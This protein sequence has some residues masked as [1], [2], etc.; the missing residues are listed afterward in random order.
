MPRLSRQF[1]P[2]AAQRFAWRRWLL[3][4]SLL[5]ALASAPANAEPLPKPI[6][7]EVK[8]TRLNVRARPGLQYEA[9]GQ[10][11]QGD[12][13][14]VLAVEGDWVGIAA[15]PNCS[16]WVP[17]NFLN[18]AVVGSL[19]TPVYAGPNAVFSSYVVLPAGASVKILQ[20]VDGK[21][22]RIVTPESATLWVSRDYLALERPIPATPPPPPVASPQAAVIPPPVTPTPTPPPAKVR[23]PEVSPPGDGKPAG[24]E[25]PAQPSPPPREVPPKPR[26]VPAVAPTTARLE[27]K[28]VERPA[29][30]PLDPKLLPPPLPDPLLSASSGAPPPMPEPPAL[31]PRPDQANGLPAAPV[32]KAPLLDFSRLL[33]LSEHLE[34]IGGAITPPI[35]RA[36]RIQTLSDTTVS[37]AIREI[38]EG[39]QVERH[40]ILV[41][42]E[43]R[44]SART[45]ALA[46]QVEDIL[47]PI[48]YLDKATPG[49]AAALWQPVKVTGTLTWVRD[50]PR[51]LLRVTELT[52]STAQP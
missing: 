19:P 12:K 26:Q 43:S 49:L 15:P 17:S 4:T 34:R 40:G 2:R 33:R 31:T 10:V 3:G 6:T 1:L 41:Q 39:R 8:A 21:W 28:P 45:Y 14:T 37:A 44:D 16:A 50:W 46:L 20:E 5:A 51:P 38:G 47:L 32:N 25:P 29:A 27:P 22:T 36:L 13:V 7:G 35:N 42:L 23:T 11:L 52:L 18:G 9:V 48:V 24:A 30:P